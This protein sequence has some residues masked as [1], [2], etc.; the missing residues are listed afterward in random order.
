MLKTLRAGRASGFLRE[1][2]ELSLLADRLSQT[3][4]HIGLGL[5]HR[6]RDVDRV[7]AAP[8][9]HGP[10]WCARQTFPATKTWT[11]R[12]PCRQ[13]KTSCERGMTGSHR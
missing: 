7:G 4:L 1:D 2:I 10:R 12:A 5:F 11:G 6:Y 9:R 3:M 13:L 8:L